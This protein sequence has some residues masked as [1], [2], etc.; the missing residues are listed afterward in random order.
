MALKGPLYQALIKKVGSPQTLSR[1]ALRLIQDCGPMTQDEARLVIAHDLGLRLE[2]FGVGHEALE[3]VRILK[4]S[5]ATVAAHSQGTST[6][7][8]KSRLPAARTGRAAH[9]NGSKPR[10]PA[11]EFSDRRFHEDVVRSSRRLYSSGHRTEAVSAAFRSINNR[12]K[13]ISG[14]KILDGT[15]LM[16]QAFGEQNPL[17]QLNAISNVTEKD[18]HSGLRSLMAGAMLALRNPRVHEDIW[19]PDADADAVLE[20][21]ALA[22][23]LHRY[24][25]RCEGYKRQ[26]KP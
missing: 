12:V 3:R 9:D 20:C 15:K 19:Q 25:D 17:L 11:A 14:L 4:A 26:Q 7:S 22:S 21:L 10:T 5:G 13:S 16:N 23:L 6:T 2:H 1:W 8:E 18:E 24:L